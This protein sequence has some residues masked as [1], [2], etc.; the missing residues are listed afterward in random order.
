M[1]GSIHL[2]ISKRLRFCTYFLAIE[3]EINSTPVLKILKIPSLKTK[4]NK[5]KSMIITELNFLE[6]Q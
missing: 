3:T 1:S 5:K 4:A 6:I 2:M